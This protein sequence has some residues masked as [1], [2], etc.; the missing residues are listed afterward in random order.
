MNGEIPH[1]K[2]QCARIAGTARPH[3]ILVIQTA[4]HELSE[5]QPYGQQ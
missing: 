2:T 3:K 5:F 4:G 1:D